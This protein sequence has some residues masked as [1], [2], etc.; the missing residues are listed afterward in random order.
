MPE[1]VLILLLIL[2]TWWWILLPIFLY[3]ML[4]SLYRWWISWE[5]WYPSNDWILVEIVP[6]QE[7][8]KPFRAMEDIFTALW[9]VYDGPNWREVWCAGQLNPASFW[10]SFEMASVAGEVHFYARILRGM[11]RFFESTIHAHYPDIEIFEAEDYTKNMAKD[12]PNDKYDM[13]AEDYILLK[14][15]AFPIRT[16]E[17][18]E[19]RAEET[20]AEKRIDPL[21]G[22]LEAMAKLRRG[23]Q[24]WFQV[25]IN[26]ILD[27]DVPWITNGKKMVA[28]LAKRDVADDDRSIIGQAAQLLTTGKMPFEPIEKQESF[29]P[30][31]MKLTPGER[32]TLAG[33]EN[34]IS[35][36]GFNVIMRSVYIYERDAFF[37]AHGK[38]ARSYMMHFATSGSNS[39]IF[40]GKTRTRVHFFFR[41]RRL[42][43]RK[44]KLFNNYILRFPTSFPHRLGKG[45]MN[46]NAEELA[47]VFHFSGKSSILPS[48]IPRLPAKKFGPPPS[49][50]TE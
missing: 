8:L 13:Y 26:P 20:E 50:P 19:I 49:L 10:I 34:K 43:K 18:F 36:L 31:E 16:Y 33:V 7:I 1:F 38:I 24:F 40:D 45:T 29:I 32:E 39:L 41:K 11:L 28:K 42:Y 17:F 14:D 21:S 9:A 27:T 4:S 15:N 35:K 46:M 30:P 6:P 47:T 12:V 23:E 25:I 37:S 48:G 2:K 3:P 5:I 22:F 44:R